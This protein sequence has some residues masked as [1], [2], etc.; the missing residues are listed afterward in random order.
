[1]G[2]VSAVIL[3]LS[4]VLKP[5]AEINWWVILWSVAIAVMGYLARNLQGEIA[6][7][8][9]LVGS[10]AAT[11]VAQNSS[12]TGLVFYDVFVKYGLPL[13]VAIAG[14]ALPTVV[15]QK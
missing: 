7:I 11:F 9:G 3:A 13:L 4:E 2:I 15:K 10:A 14:A 8:I 1:M 5:G 6:T 12:A